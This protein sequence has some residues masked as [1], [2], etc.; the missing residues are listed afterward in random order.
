MTSVKNILR[1]LP[2]KIKQYEKINTRILIQLSLENGI[3][4]EE[5]KESTVVTIPKLT[6]TI[7]IV[8]LEPLIY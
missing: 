3:S 1:N 4:P 8:N 7:N 2:N 6:K 5:W